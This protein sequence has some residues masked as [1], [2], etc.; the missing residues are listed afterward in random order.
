MVERVGMQTNGQ[1]VMRKRGIVAELVDSAAE[2][3]RI[4]LILCPETSR[5]AEKEIKYLFSNKEMN[6]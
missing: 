1:Y 6:G 5:Q 4:K 2:I 3:E